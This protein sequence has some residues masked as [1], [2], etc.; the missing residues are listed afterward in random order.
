MRRV[1]GQAPALARSRSGGNAAALDAAWI[2][3]R[4]PADGRTYSLYRT[5]DYLDRRVPNLE[6]RTYYIGD[7]DS[8]VPQLGGRSDLREPGLRRLWYRD[9]LR[10]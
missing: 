6:H 3:S 10:R 5:A 4:P 8:F 2:R 9:P 7:A 1:F